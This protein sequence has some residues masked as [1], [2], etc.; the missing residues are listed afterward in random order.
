MVE[1][2]GIL[3]V[4]SQWRVGD[5]RHQKALWEGVGEPVSFLSL[6][7]FILMCWDTLDVSNE[8]R[9]DVQYCL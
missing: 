5:S 3:V 9:V 6:S 4:N 8:Q 1:R 2:V 7:V